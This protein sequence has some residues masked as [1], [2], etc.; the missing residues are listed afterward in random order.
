MEENKKQ[1]F[2]SHTEDLPEEMLFSE[3]YDE[4]NVLYDTNARRMSRMLF[5][6]KRT[7]KTTFSM[8]PMPGTM[9]NSKRMMMRRMEKRAA[10]KP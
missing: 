4:D 8:T 5:M 9:K 3:D 10:R 2:S 1:G 6:T 7:L